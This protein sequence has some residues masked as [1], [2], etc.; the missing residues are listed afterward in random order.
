MYC[1]VLSIRLFS[2]EEWIWCLSFRNRQAWGYHVPPS[3]DT[4]CFP[5]LLIKLSRNLS[6]TNMFL[7]FEIVSARIYLLFESVATHNQMYSDP[8]LIKISSI[9]YSEI[10]SFQENLSGI[11]FLNPIPNC[12]MASLHLV[13]MKY[14]F[15]NASGW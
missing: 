15:G 2:R 8:T 9:M 7:S 3:V 5:W 4:Q 11:V 10:V 14:C 1:I 12:N 6:A 13:Y